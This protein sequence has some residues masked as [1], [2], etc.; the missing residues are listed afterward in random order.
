MPDMAKSSSSLYSRLL[1]YAFR[2]KRFFIYSIVGFVLFAAAQ[3]ML[4]YTIELFVN[5]LEG[6]PTKWVEFLPK[7]LVDSA[8]L[9]PVI[10]IVVSIVRGIGYFL[11]HYN[12]SRVGLHVVNTLRKEVFSH[13]LYL[14]Q[15]VFDKSSSGEQISLV[16]YNI[17]QVTASVTRAVKII[18]EDGFSLIAL[19]CV[20]CLVLFELEI[21]TYFLCCSADYEPTGIYC[22][23]I[24]PPSEP[25]NT[26][27]R[28]QDIPGY[29]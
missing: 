6:K 4:L 8:Y 1:S 10:V 13:L 9:L 19:L 16:I 23:T 17:E 26:T 20:L 25:K 7:T 24:L 21:N 14:P 3:A 18:L 2:Y 15:F 5:Q 27:I 28:W 11:G 29:Q 22:C 12:I